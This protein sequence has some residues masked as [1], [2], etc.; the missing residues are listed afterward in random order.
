MHNLCRRLLSISLFG[1][2]HHVASQ[3]HKGHA[4]DGV[5]IKGS[6]CSCIAAFT[7][8]LYDRNL[9]Q[10]RYVQFFCQTFGTFLAEQV[11]LVVRKFGRSEPSHVFYQA[12]DRHVHL[13]VGVHVDA[14]A[15]IGQSHLLRGADNHRSRN[16]QGLEQSQVDVT[17]ARRGIQH[18]IIQFAPVSARCW[19][20]RH[21]TA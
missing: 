13:V 8:A 18:E 7:N 17:G 16:G 2:C 12:E 6:R 14:L 20:Y 10:Q 5:L 21:A 15:C 9:S 11:I 3:V 19:P 4:G 1:L